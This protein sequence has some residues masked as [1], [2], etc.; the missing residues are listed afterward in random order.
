MGSTS[1]RLSKYREG[2]IMFKVLVLAAWMLG[3]AWAVSNGLVHE[4]VLPA[5]EIAHN[6][7]F[8]G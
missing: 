1:Y 5:F 3:F 7:P 2:L 6:L 4:I 8:G